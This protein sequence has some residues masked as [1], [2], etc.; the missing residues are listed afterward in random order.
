MY[1]ENE[2]CER[3]ASIYPDIGKCGININVTYNQPEKAWVVHLE[4]GSHSLDHFLEMMDA[5][6]CMEGKQCVALGLEIAQLRKN[7]E[8]KQF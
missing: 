5:D 7:I 2:L 1:S 8:G 4:K 6:K 3:I